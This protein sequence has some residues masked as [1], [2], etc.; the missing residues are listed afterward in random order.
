MAH[1][2]QSPTRPTHLSSYA[3]ACLQALARRG[4]GDALSL[5]GGLGLLHYL[6]YR[7]TH[8]V[9]AWWDQGTSPQARLAILDV[10]EDALRP[11]GEVTTRTWGEVTSVELA[12]D[13]VKVFSF[14][15]AQRSAQLESSG[16]AP[17]V[18]VKLDSLSDLVASK[19]VALVERGAPRDFLDIHAVCQAE[20]L[21]EG[22]CWQLWERRQRLS[23]SDVDRHRARL[24]VETHV[25]R[26]ELQRPLAEIADPEQRA[27]A[28][29]VR[30]WFKEVFLNALPT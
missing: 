14:Q 6:D 9:D 25:K 11:W 23:G 5:G 27:A 21:T 26:I 22:E 24:A 1:K 8:D 17:W 16:S 28:A 10:I 30:V 3:E 29:Q 13:G 15:I 19:M 18:D 12:R 4:W 2:G 7:P 20:L